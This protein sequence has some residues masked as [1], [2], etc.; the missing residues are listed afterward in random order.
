MQRA[1]TKIYLQG[2][3][4]KGGKNGTHIYTLKM[5]NQIKLFINYEA[6]G[7]DKEYL[8]RLHTNA[9]EMFETLSSIWDG[10]L[11][12]MDDELI[13]DLKNLVNKI[14]GETK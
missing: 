2:D 3:K 6:D 7:L 11:F 12:G 10:D 5:D 9:Q 1:C 13:Q 4:M 8:E 14:K